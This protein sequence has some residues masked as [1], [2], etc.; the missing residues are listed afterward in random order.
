MFSLRVKYSFGA[1]KGWKPD[2][3]GELAWLARARSRGI[4]PR[5]IIADLMQGGVSLYNIHFVMI[6]L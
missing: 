4:N 3:T 2:M 6:N 1:G 5:D